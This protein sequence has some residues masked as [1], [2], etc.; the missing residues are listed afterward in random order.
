MY[1]FALVDKRD[2]DKLRK[3]KSLRFN[4]YTKQFL[5][6]HNSKA[7]WSFHKSQIKDHIWKKI[8]KNDT[9][10]FSVPKEP[11]DVIGHVSKKITDKKI[12]KSMWPDSLDSY[13]ITY[14]L[15]FDKI[16]AVSLLYNEM[17]DNAVS[18]RTLMLPGI[19]EIKKSYWSTLQVQTQDNTLSHTV[20]PKRLPKTHGKIPHK[21]RYEVYRFVRDPIVVRKLKRLYDNQCQIC[22]FTFEYEKNKFY[23]EVH[24]YNPMEEG[25]PD[26]VDNMIV[27]CPNHHSQFDYKMIAIDPDGKTIINRNGEKIGLINFKDDHRL[28][29]KNLS[30]QLRV[31]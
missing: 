3:F 22:G 31:N 14:F 28:S 15:L 20:R 6:D 29:T 7:V 2:S 10:C 23:S 12:G 18:K 25:G 4:T 9:V 27:V 26:D 19:Y 8:R 11:F 13:Q 17:I 1:F 5:D 24:H 21:S 30:S 16:Q